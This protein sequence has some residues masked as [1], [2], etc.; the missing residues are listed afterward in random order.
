MG[1]FKNVFYEKK[2]LSVSIGN[3]IVEMCY[4]F[5]KDLFITWIKEEEKEKDK[6]FF[7]TICN[8]ILFFL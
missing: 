6:F 3:K 4:F 2:S 1:D 8:K 5:P 7:K